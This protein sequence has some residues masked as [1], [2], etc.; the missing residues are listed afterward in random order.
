ML[1]T[2]LEPLEGVRLLGQESRNFGGFDIDVTACERN[3]VPEV[4]VRLHNATDKP[5][6]WTPNGGWTSSGSWSVIRDGAGGGFMH[7][8]GCSPPYGESDRKPTAAELVGWLVMPGEY[9]FYQTSYEGAGWDDA[10]DAEELGPILNWST[11]FDLSL[12]V[13]DEPELYDGVW[14]NMVFE[15]KIGE[16]DGGFKLDLRGKQRH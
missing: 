10:L 15:V 8:I 13:W 5:A 11:T 7:S 6:W 3:G 4:L 12:P 14:V 2:L 16:G 9:R 1:F